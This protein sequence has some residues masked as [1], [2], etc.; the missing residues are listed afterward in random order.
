MRSVVSADAGGEAEPSAVIPGEHIICL[1]KAE[2][3][4]WIVP[5][6]QPPLSPLEFCARG[7]CILKRCPPLPTYS[8]HH[9]TS[10]PDHP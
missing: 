8:L 9:D 5:L 2:V 3:G 4:L 6:R 7:A 1:V 10:D